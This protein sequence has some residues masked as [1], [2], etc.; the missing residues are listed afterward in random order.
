MEQLRQD[1]D[2]LKLTIEN[3]HFADIEKF[4]NQIFSEQKDDI[5]KLTI[6]VSEQKA[7]INK[8]TTQVSEQKADNEK[9]K[10]DIE[11]YKSDIEKLTIQMSEHE[12]TKNEKYQADMDKLTAQ[13]SEQNAD[14]NEKYYADIKTY[15]ASN[16]KMEEK[17]KML[18]RQVDDLTRKNGEQQ[19]QMEETFLSG[20]RNGSK[21]GNY[22]H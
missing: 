16:R 13:V 2:A 3:Q 9:Y 22:V 12:K 7:G 8:L 15:Q 4:T 18:M 17:V 19:Q 14:I 21:S 6:Q 20:Y 10:A 1:F 5:N 11:K